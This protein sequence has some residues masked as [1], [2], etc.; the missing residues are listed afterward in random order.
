MKKLNYP[1]NGIEAVCRKNIDGCVN[2]LTTAKN[3]CNLS[4]P[5]DFSYY[6]YLSN[7]SG[8]LTQYKREIDSINSQITDSNRSYEELCDDLTLDAK[9]IEISTIKQRNRLIY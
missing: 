3:L 8:T 1:E 2:K 9:N 6:S 7:L 5:G 4:I